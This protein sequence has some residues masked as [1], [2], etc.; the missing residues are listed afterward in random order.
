MI[1]SFAMEKDENCI[2]RNSRREGYQQS[3]GYPADNIRAL[4]PDYTIFNESHVKKLVSRADFS[5]KI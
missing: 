2:R 5:F 3:A 1:V 4:P